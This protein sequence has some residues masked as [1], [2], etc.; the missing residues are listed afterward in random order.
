MSSIERIIT[1]EIVDIN[2]LKLEIQLV[3]SEG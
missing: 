2:K 3:I 1:Q